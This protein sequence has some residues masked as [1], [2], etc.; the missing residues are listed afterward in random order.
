[1][2]MDF[3]QCESVRPLNLAENRF[4]ELLITEF[5]LQRTKVGAE[6]VVL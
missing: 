1:L 6:L 2:K 4:L 5:T 3:T